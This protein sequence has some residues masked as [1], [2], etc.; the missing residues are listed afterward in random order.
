MRAFDATGLGADYGGVKPSQSQSHRAPK[1]ARTSPPARGGSWQGSRGGLARLGIG[2]FPLLLACSAGRAAA[3][4]RAPKA[5]QAVLAR[6]YDRA[7]TEYRW[8]HQHPELSNQE[9]E[10]AA[11][12]AKAL[13]ALGFA[14]QEGIGGTGLTATL[15]GRKAGGGSG[16]VVLYRADMD[17]LPVQENTGLSYSSRNQ[18]VMH[19]CGHDV[20]MA[21]A[22]GALEVMA[23]TRGDWAGTVLFV[24]QPAEELGAGAR[25]MLADPEFRK[26]MATLGKPTVALALH[27]AANLPAGQV[28]LSPGYVTANVDSVDIVLHGRGGHGAQP[29]EAI[30]PVVMAAEVVLQLQ[31]IVARRIPP[32][33]R[34]VV[35]VGKI[36][37]GTKH[38]II[39]PSAELLLTVRSYDD[40]TRQTLLAE[41][42]HIA[43][44]VATSYHAP[45]PP[46]VTQ[47]DEFTPSGFNDEAWSQRLKARFEALLGA[48]QVNDMPPTMGGEDFAQFGRQLGIPGVLWRLGAVPPDAF[49]RRAERSLPGLHSDG[50]APD[51]AAAL[52]VGIQTV[53]AALHEALGDP[54]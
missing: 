29:H 30:D 46:E 16:P 22:L 5:P 39:P 3:A 37:A 38:N 6:A 17:G 9:R 33:R 13:R 54:S 50:W 7:L 52:P 23:R 19:A 15:R 32:D 53:V 48:E 20:H 35:T 44:S 1:A 41:I 51:A 25:Q 31:T 21:T 43:H 18:G 42:E 47:R 49:A 34:A 45:R 26:L 28:A 27:D 40:A 14:V 36:Q 4:A 2:A 11:H 24:A 12:L 10:T 8:L